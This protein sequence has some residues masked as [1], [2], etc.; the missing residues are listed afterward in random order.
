M[1]LPFPHSKPQ[2]QSELIE[3]NGGFLQAAHNMPEPGHPHPD[4]QSH[5]SVSVQVKS[6]HGLHSPL[7][8]PNPE[9]HGLF[10]SHV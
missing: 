9:Q 4:G 2:Q 6:L 1:H 3:H 10:G 7:T 5:V 8:H